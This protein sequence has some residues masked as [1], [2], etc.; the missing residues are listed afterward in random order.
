MAPRSIEPIRTFHWIDALRGAA[1]I[2]IVVFHYHHFYLADA[3]G[4]ALIPPTETFPYSSFLKPLF[5]P[6][7]SR[8]VELFWLISGF[9][10]AHVYLRRRT[11]AWEFS[12]ARLARLYPLHLVTLLYVAGIQAISMAS[13]GHWQ[14]YDNNDA[15]HF[16]LQ[17]F[18]ASNWISWSEG[19]SFNGPIWSV[20]LEIVV[21]GLFF[22][23]IGIMKKAPVLV[24]IL[25][26]SA[27]WAWV[28]LEPVRLPLVQIGVLECSGFFFLGC[29]LRGLRP[30][31]AW[32]RAG[33]LAL[34]GGCAALLGLVTGWELMVVSGIAAGVVSLAAGLDRLLRQRARGWALWAISATASIWFTSRSR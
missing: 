26:C 11:S 20:S 33:G 22:L 3:G 13:Q 21:Y 16:V 34:S 30:D 10:F 29:L 8:A 9:V 27:S 32:A 2:V 12:F 15:R 25:L 19:L 31:L 1:A 4:R 14:I 17:L 6:I 24:P 7:A 5:E 23:S 18:M 28:L